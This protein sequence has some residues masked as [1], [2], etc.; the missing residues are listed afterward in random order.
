MSQQNSKREGFAAGEDPHPFFCVAGLSS[1]LPTKRAFTP[2]F[3]GLWGEG[4]RRE[5]PVSWSCGAPYIFPH[6]LINGD[7][8]IWRVSS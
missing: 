6:S 7:R 8:G 3:D 4:T 2:V 5:R 1:P